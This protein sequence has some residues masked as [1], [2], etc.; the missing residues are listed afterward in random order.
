MMAISLV[1]IFSLL[2]KE[3]L[4][5]P[6]SDCTIVMNRYTILTG[7]IPDTDPVQYECLEKLCLSAVI[8]ARDLV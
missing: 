3:Q 5:Q 4:I 6:F 2:L 7:I 1:P 8:L